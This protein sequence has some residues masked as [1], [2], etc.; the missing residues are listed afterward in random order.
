MNNILKQQVCIFKV[1][2]FTNFTF[3][4]IKSLFLG[5]YL[6]LGC[7]EKMMYGRTLVSLD[8][9]FT[10]CA[11][12]KEFTLALYDNLKVKDKISENIK[13]CL[14]KIK[15]DNN[16]VRVI[17]GKLKSYTDGNREND[18]KPLIIKYINCFFDRFTVPKSKIKNSLN[19]IN[20]SRNSNNNNDT[21]IDKNIVERL[22]E[23]LISASR[24]PNQNILIQFI[25]KKVFSPFLNEKSKEVGDW[26]KQELLV[27]MKKVDK[28]DLEQV[29][30]MIQMIVQLL[31]YYELRNLYGMKQI[32]KN[33][34]FNFSE[35]LASQ[36]S[37]LKGLF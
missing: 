24:S 21:K 31:V 20:Y 12:I 32:C 9:F 25:P 7:L 17:A 14:K 15:I 30:M 6:L 37:I 2:I 4:K 33:I 8:D 27:Q 10:D 35:I 11:N 13:S 23:E 19:Q 16:F 28:K 3:L 34:E 36:I 18:L 22:T 5:G 29:T 1:K 26:L